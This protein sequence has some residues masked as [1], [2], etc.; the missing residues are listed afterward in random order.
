MSKAPAVIG[1]ATMPKPFSF[2]ETTMRVQFLL[3][4]AASF[5]L[6]ACGDLTADVERAKQGAVELGQEA[7]RAGADV[8]D[9][10]SACVLAGQSPA[11]CS[12]L[13]ERLGPEVSSEQIDALSE[14]VRAT[15]DGEGAQAETR[16]ADGVNAQTR[17]A[18][19]QCATRSAIEGAVSEGAN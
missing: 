16:T 3:I 6:A 1:N 8:L 9:T 7:L 2:S 14:M 17:E 12:C 18:I 15:L 11:F 10:E 13:S 4:A 5:G 19:V